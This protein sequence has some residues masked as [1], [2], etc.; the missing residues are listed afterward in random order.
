MKRSNYYIIVVLSTLILPSLIVPSIAY[1][2]TQGYAEDVKIGFTWINGIIGASEMIDAGYQKAIDMGCQIEHREYGW[3]FLN[4]TLYNSLYEWDQIY[5]DRYPTFDR[6]LD[7][8]VVTSNSTSIPFQHDFKIYLTLPTN[9]TRFNDTAIL[10]SL[11]N[12]TIDAIQILDPDYISFS[13][14]INGF[15]EGYYNETSKGFD[16]AMYPD[17]I[18]LLEQ[19]YD[20]IKVNY[21]DIQ[22]MTNFRYQPPSDLTL[23]EAMIHQFNDT[24]DIFSVSPRIFTDDLGFLDTPETASEVLDRFSSFANLTDKKIAITNTY[25]ISDSRAGSSVGY[26]SNYVKYLFDF[27]EL[28]D[29]Q[30]EFV[31]WYT[32]FDYPPGYLSSYFSPFLEVHATAGL[33]SPTGEPKMAYYTWIEEMQA[34]GKLPGY[35]KAWKIALGSLVFA[36]VLGFLVYA[37]VMEGLPQFKERLKKEG[38][39][40]EKKPDVISFE[41]EKKPRK[42]SKKPKTIEFTTEK[43]DNNQDNSDEFISD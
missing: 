25:M 42:K 30:I 39:E 28:Y 7:I 5:L 4:Y 21:T 33:F 2:P 14:E 31:C 15:F 27:I 34:A 3:A 17:F 41:K 8:S 10:N 43:I 29:S 6:S 40:E 24:C 18:D 23:I 9:N 26:Q 12:T 20:F 35:W 37:Y 19:M 1:T 16:T 36:G 22:V 38:K 32:V 11:R 13:T